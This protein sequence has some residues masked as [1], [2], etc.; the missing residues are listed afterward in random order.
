MSCGV[1]CLPIFGR[2]AYLTGLP[3]LTAEW[4]FQC[5]L[6]PVDQGPRQGLPLVLQGPEFSLVEPVVPVDNAEGK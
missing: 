4:W 5:A 1:V 3:L 2:S 6:S